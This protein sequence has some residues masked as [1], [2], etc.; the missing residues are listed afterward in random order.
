[1]KAL[2]FR[3]NSPKPLQLPF[4]TYFCMMRRYTLNDM[5]SAFLTMQPS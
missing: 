1:M 3:I 4:T 2:S 5:V